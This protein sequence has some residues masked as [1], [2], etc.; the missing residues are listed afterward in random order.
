MVNKLDIIFLLTLSADKQLV[1]LTYGS[2]KKHIH[3]TSGMV[4]QFVR[5]LM[6][7]WKRGKSTH[8][9]TRIDEFSKL[10]FDAIYENTF[11]TL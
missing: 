7:K 9:Y 4:I 6:M 3:F 1:S 2:S 10:L 8:R 5:A 11:C